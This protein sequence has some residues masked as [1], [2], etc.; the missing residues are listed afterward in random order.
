MDMKKYLK[1][2]GRKSAIRLANKAGTKYV[3]LTQIASGYRK[4][5]G[6]L[7]LLLERHSN[8]KLTRHE[9]RPDLYPKGFKK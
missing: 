7:T 6:R 8:E 5:S 3:Y 4:P 2:E 1:E 9:L